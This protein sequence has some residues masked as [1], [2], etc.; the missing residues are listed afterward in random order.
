MLQDL[1]QHW[2]EHSMRTAEKNNLIKESEDNFT[3]DDVL[4]GLTAVIY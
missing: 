2:P 3:G 1:K 4:E